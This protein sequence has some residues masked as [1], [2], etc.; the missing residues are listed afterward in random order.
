VI[1]C[2]FCRLRFSSVSE[3]NSHEEECEKNPDNNQPLFERVGHSSSYSGYK[4]GR[5]YLEFSYIAEGSN[6]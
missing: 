3:R 1:C 5:G 4:K 2:K 6:G